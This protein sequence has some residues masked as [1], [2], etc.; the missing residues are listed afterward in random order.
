MPDS[1]ALIPAR[2]GSQRI[3]RKNV[4]EF[5]GVPALT[6]VVRTL[7][8]SGTVSEVVVSTDDA[9]IAEVA[10]AAGAVA[11]FVRPDSL[12]DSRTG[13]R[14]V[15]QHA[16]RELGLDGG[17][18]LG[19]FYPTAV[20]TTVEDVAASAALFAEGRSDFVLAVAEFPAPIERALTVSPEGDLEARWPEQLGARSQDLPR[21]YHDIGQFYWGH[22]QEWLTDVP[23]V[24]ARC[25]GYVVPTWRAVD[26]D[27][28]DD[29]ERAELVF[30]MLHGRR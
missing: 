24:V 26:I 30:G 21:S 14:P 19:V 11:P 27:T 7:V 17:T 3:P 10:K 6:R 1:M 9:E 12:A 16:V 4:R 18:T 28:P 13:A 23:V 5:L 8:E 20:L 2:G 15:I 22:A 29:W 25:R